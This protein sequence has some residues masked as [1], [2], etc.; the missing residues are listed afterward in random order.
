MPSDLLKDVPNEPRI[1]PGAATTLVAHLRQNPRDAA[2]DPDELATELGVDAAFVRHVLRA[3]RV[4]DEEDPEDAFQIRISLRPL[5]KWLKTVLNRFDRLV[6]RPVRFLFVTLVLAGMFCIGLEAFAEVT[7]FTASGEGFQVSLGSATLV[8]LLTGALHMACYFRQANP[9]HVLYGTL[10]VWAV[11]GATSAVGVWRAAAGADSSLRLMQVAITL[12]G[13]TMFALLYAGLGSL[14]TVVGGWLRYWKLDRLEER[15]SRQDLLERYFELQTR[16]RGGRFAQ[17]RESRWETS[18]FVVAFRRR[19]NL[20]SLVG[21]AQLSLTL[22]LVTAPGNVRLNDLQPQNHLF[23]FLAMS[24]IGALTWTSHVT[25]GFLSGNMRRG[26]ISSALYSAGAVL[27]TLIPFGPYGF[28]YYATAG[29]VVSTIGRAILMAGVAAVAGLGAEVRSRAAR[30]RSLQQDDPAAVAAEMLRI[31][32]RLS[33]GAT[34]VCVMVVDAARSSEMKAEADPLAVEY[35]FR[36]YQDW[37]EH[38]SEAHEGR[39]HSTAGDGAVVAF[40]TSADALATAKRLQSDVARFNREISRLRLP[41]RLRIGLHRGHV[42]GEIEEVEFTEVIDIAA[43]V[44]GVAPVS[45]IALSDSVVAELP[46]EDV[47]PLAKEVDGHKV[48]LALNPVED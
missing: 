41:F 13:V 39:V 3:A 15:M 18:P 14:A 44:Q 9:R 5:V 29:I 36:E 43:H 23:V 8:I 12:S 48:Y 45:G 38:H 30:E 42:A 31:H 27:P 20:W 47:V 17:A 25:I 35:S 22:V 46:G 21:G 11:L 24:V 2:R 28:G 7:G 37:I 32:W 16:L 26:A 40:G 6:A 4:P 34:H 1:D 10:G 19:P 33:D